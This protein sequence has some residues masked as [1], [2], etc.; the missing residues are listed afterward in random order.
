[1]KK[2]A[3]LLIL[4]S[5]LLGILL[6]DSCKKDKSLAVLTTSNVTG[7]TINAATTG[8]NI[9]SS[10]GADITARGV[11]WGT[12]RN[13]V[14]TGSKTTDG[15]GTG[16]FSSSITGLTPN[17]QYYVRA[18]ATNS[19]GTAYGNEV[20]FTTSEIVVPTLT[21]TA[22]SAILLTTATSG[23]NIT[24]DGGASVTARGVCFATT[25][26]PDI[27]GTITSDGTGTGVFTS[28]LTGLTPA[29]MYYARAYATN[30][31]GTAY[32]NEIT[33]T[34]ASIVAP[35]LT[36]V[37][38]SAITLTSA[39]S[40]GV[41]T[42]DGG[43]AVTARG[44]CWATTTGP[45]TSNNITTDGNGTGTF[46]SAITG[47]TAG[48]TYY[49]RAYATNSIGTSYGNELTFETSPLHSLH[50]QQLRL[51][52]LHRQLLYQVVK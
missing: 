38:I 41:I 7:I 6:T 11:C 12:S 26:N 52:L 30:S 47:L 2:I 36:T 48:T 45:T 4:T 42:S 23:G 27:T 1:M 17:T 49:V 5:L 20:S 13:P 50:L 28:S 10:G 51:P 3:K 33:F 25:A 32:G 40:G 44:V 22:A 24:N 9:T 34:T 8:G 35:T 29:T 21:T 18:Y 46:A 31:A 15:K 39:A 19:V 16:S 14:V 43:A 37:D